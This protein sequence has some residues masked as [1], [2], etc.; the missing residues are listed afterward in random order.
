MNLKKI[1]LF[2]SKIKYNYNFPQVFLQTITFLKQI[3]I[4]LKL[5]NMYCIYI[6][7]F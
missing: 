1:I 5:P 2:Y 6:R 4:A 3:F 7:E